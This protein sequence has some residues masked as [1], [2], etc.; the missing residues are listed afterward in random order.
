MRSG[1]GGRLSRRVQLHTTVRELLRTVGLLVL[2]VVVYMLPPSGAFVTSTCHAFAPG[3]FVRHHAQRPGSSVSSSSQR[4]AKGWLQPPVRP[5]HCVPNALSTPAAEHSSSERSLRELT[6]L[7]DM[8]EAEMDVREAA[9]NE[10]DCVAQL[11]CVVFEQGKDMYRSQRQKMR[12]SPHYLLA[13]IYK[14]TLMVAVVRALTPNARQ[15]CKDVVLADMQELLDLEW[16]S[17]WE[18]TQLVEQLERH[19]ETRSELVVGSVDCSVHEM[20]DSSLTL[21]RMCYVSSMAVRSNVRQRGV[22]QQLLVLAVAHARNIFGV[23]QM[24]LHVEELNSGALRLYQRAAFARGDLDDS[25]MNNMDRMLRLVLQVPPAATLYT[26]HLSLE[27]TH[28]SRT[29]QQAQPK[30]SDAWALQRSTKMHHIAHTLAAQQVAK[31]ATVQPPPLAHATQKT[32]PVVQCPPA[33]EHIPTHPHRTISPC[34]P[35]SLHQPP[36]F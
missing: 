33:S 28:D 27:T 36:V 15:V 20:L 18:H 25:H 8:N 10:G 3:G 26:R 11:R 22:G 12:T 13:G 31:H 7:L 29:R 35:I 23:K 6:R 30:R 19:W 32:L 4:P 34:T 2:V 14:T 21:R 17:T 9:G 5:A 1:G 16:I 24:F